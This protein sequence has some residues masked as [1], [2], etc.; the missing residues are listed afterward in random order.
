[1]YKKWEGKSNGKSVVIREV[2][3]DYDHHDFEIIVDGEYIGTIHPDD[4]EDTEKIIKELNTSDINDVEGWE[5]GCGNAVSFDTDSAFYEYWHN[6][7]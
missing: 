1:M 3:F 5:D 2:D 4:V 7:N 6:D